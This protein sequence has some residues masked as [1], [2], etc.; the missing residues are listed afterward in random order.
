MQNDWRSNFWEFLPGRSSRL[1][2]LIYLNDDFEGGCTTFFTPSL[3]HGVLESRG[4]RPHTVCGTWHDSFMCDMT[5]T[6][7]MW[8]GSRGVRPH[9]VCGTWLVHMWHDSFMGDM[10]YSRVTCLIHVWLKSRGVQPHTEFVC[11]ITHMTWHEPIMCDATHSYMWHDSFM[12]DMIYVWQYSFMCDVAH[13]CELPRSCVTWLIHVWCPSRSRG[14]WPHT[15]F[16]CGIT[17]MTWHESFMCDVT[18][19]Y[20]TCLIH[21]TWLIHMGHDSNHVVCGCMLYMY[22][23]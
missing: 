4:V 18:H 15:V 22:V 13:S 12:C 11:I 19:S 3:E 6:C 7:V 2:F 17:H 9:T 1:T 23:L 20:V 21:V 5:H 16:V 8:L 14:V 10:T